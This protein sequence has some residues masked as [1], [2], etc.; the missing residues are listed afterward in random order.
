[1][2]KLL[3]PHG[4]VEPITAA[5][6]IIAYVDG[7]VSTMNPAIAADGSNAETA[8][9][10]KVRPHH[11]CNVPYAEVHDFNID[12]VDL[13]STCQR[14]TRC[15]AAYCLKTKNGKQQ[16]S[17]N[18][19]KPLQQV[20]TIETDEKDDEPRICTA[21]NDSLLNSYH[22]VQLSGWRA[23]VDMQYIVSRGRVIKYTA[24][25]ATK[26][27][28]RSKALKSVYQTVLKT[29]DD[30]TNSLKFAQKLL[31][32]SVGERDYSAQET[33][34]LL[35]QLPMYR[36]SRDFVY[37]SLDGS[38]ELA[39][40]LEDER[41]VTV[42]SHLDHYCARQSTPEFEVLSLK[43]FV[44]K[45]KI[46]KQVGERLIPI[47][48]NV[49]VIPRPYCSPDP[50]GSKYEQYC[51]QKQTMHK[52]FR[53]LNDLL[54]MF[55]S[56]SDAYYHFLQTGAVPPSLADDIHRLEV[57][58]RENLD[59]G[60]SE[61]EENTDEGDGHTVEDWMLICQPDTEFQQNRDKSRD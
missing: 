11:A 42:A 39:D 48:K 53:C 24:K 26:P 56:H 5:E 18:Y 13:I 57:A 54:E 12:L 46:P 16:C 19:P 1:V 27:E 15:S 2:E 45:Y 25:Y 38:R 34:H 49:A 22:P 23:N 8:P 7:L 52:P 61:D 44:E 28:T 14:H 36:T 17:F 60:E 35:L 29:L 33:C 32:S 59:H 58:E 31:F 41:C 47:K 4:D 51:R 43:Q 40:K 6:Q 50:N 37:L 55:E 21:R 30:D 10:P 20:T 3:S 9:P